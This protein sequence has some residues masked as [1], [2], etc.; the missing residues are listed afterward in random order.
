MIFPTSV[1]VVLVAGNK[2]MEKE[3]E[4]AKIE[5]E[6][7]GWKVNFCEYEQRNGSPEVVILRLFPGGELK[8]YKI[9]E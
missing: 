1:A 4:S 2:N 5:L 3:K 9:H 8:Q 7:K 6:K